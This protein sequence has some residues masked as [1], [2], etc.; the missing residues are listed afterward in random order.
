MQVLFQ[1]ILVMSYWR[2]FTGGV[3]AGLFEGSDS[4]SAR[5]KCRLQSPVRTRY[6]HR[7][8]WIRTSHS[9]NCNNDQPTTYIRS[10]STKR[11]KPG[12][13]T[14]SRRN[15]NRSHHS[16]RRRAFHRS[17]TRRRNSARRLFSTT[18]EQSREDE[19]WP[20]WKRVVSEHK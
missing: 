8:C 10:P 4:P 19:P 9:R 3:E 18:S 11:I 12:L 15:P 14:V 20:W 13:C 7:Q 6:R 5:R 16:P 1:P 2:A 17:H